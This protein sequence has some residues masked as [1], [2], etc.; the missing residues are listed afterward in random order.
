MIIQ[1]RECS[2]EA[3]AH[4]LHCSDKDDKS[5]L[6]PTYCPQPCI[7][8]SHRASGPGLFLS[9]LIYN[10]AFLLTQWSLRNFKSPTGQNVN[11]KV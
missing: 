2:F 10:K 8:R 6:P 3:L 5:E 11:L 1:L 7:S 4:T 9:Y